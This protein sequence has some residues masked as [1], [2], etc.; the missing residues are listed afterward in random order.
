VQQYMHK[1]DSRSLDFFYSTS[2]KV[3]PHHLSCCS[4]IWIY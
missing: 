4:Y 2:K 3:V 1:V